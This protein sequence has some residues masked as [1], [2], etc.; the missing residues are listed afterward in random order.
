MNIFCLAARNKRSEPL[1]CVCVA[2]ISLVYSLCSCNMSNRTGEEM[3]AAQSSAESPDEVTATRS[4]KTTTQTTE[5][6]F[7][8]SSSYFARVQ[9]NQ[10]STPQ[11][12][13]FV[14]TQ[15]DRPLNITLIDFNYLNSF[16]HNHHLIIGT[17]LVC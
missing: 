1:L 7:N 16:I 2:E 13:H 10:S 14:G 8:Q 15:T 4:S 11:P 9:F 5:R 6:V 3:N 12:W 17:S